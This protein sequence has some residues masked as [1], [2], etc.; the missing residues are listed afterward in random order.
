MP[1]VTGHYTLNRRDLPAKADKLRVRFVPQLVN[2]KNTVLMLYPN[3][4]PG[5]EPSYVR[6]A[7]WMKLGHLRLD[8]S[9]VTLAQGFGQL[10][11]TGQQLLGLPTDPSVGKAVLKESAGTGSVYAFALDLDDCDPVE[12]KRN[13]RCKPG[14]AVIESKDN[15]N[16][17]FRLGVL[18]VGLLVKDDGPVIRTSLP[19][20]LEQLAPEEQRNLQKEI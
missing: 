3:S 10:V 7:V 9:T 13:W 18:S 17:A 19:A 15:Q 2:N 6:Y 11:V 5:F 12:I 16:P 20:F 8:D 4:E 14:E 1:I